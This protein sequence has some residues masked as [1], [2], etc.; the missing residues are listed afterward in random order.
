M[1]R[2]ENRIAV[3]TGCRRGFGEAMARLFAKEGAAVSICDIVPKD[4]LWEHVGSEIEKNG[5]RY[6]KVNV[7]YISRKMK[8]G[9]RRI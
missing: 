5:A 6:A 8:D 9:K 4:E 3:I 7:L 2:L 1:G